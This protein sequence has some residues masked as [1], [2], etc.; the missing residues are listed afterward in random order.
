MGRDAPFVRKFSDVSGSI[1]CRLSTPGRRVQVLEETK[2]LSE[3]RLLPSNFKLLTRK[4][5]K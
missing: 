2:I 4:K 1:L 3:K 5:F